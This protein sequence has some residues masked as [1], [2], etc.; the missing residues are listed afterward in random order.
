LVQTAAE[1]NA[2]GGTGRRLVEARC[3]NLLKTFLF[4]FTKTMTTNW[5]IYTLQSVRRS[6]TG[7]TLTDTFVVVAR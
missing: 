2:P 7:F 3:P 4:L 1:T 5:P 6:P